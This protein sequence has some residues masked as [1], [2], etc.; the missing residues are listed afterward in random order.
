[1]AIGVFIAY[2]IG[3][4]LYFPGFWAWKGATPGKM[5]MGIEIVNTDG[6]PIGFGRAI[7]RYIG[8]FVSGIII[9]IGFFM[10]AWDGKKQGLHDKMAGTIVIEA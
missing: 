4:I 9:Y 3:S 5:M 8:Y 1:M 6:S 7:V 2:F 10:I